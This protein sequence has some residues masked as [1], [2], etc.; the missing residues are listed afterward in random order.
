MEGHEAEPEPEVGTAA[1]VVG[2][3]AQ[4]TWRVS[5]SSR[6]GALLL[7]LLLLLLGPGIAAIG[8]FSEGKTTLNTR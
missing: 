1:A 6:C 8:R 4:V 7:L 3:A 5:R 2:A